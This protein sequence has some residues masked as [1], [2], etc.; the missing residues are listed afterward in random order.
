MD[1]KSFLFGEEFRNFMLNAI[2]GSKLVSGGKEILC[3]CKYCPDSSNPEH[4][5]MYIHIPD[6]KDDIA[7]FNCFKCHTSGIIDSRRLIEW[8]IYDFDVALN[9]DGIVKEASAYNKLR[10]YSRIIYRFNNGFYN[11]DLAQYKLNYIN[12]RLGLNLTFADCLRNKIIFNLKD[13]LDYNGIRKYTRHENIIQ[14]LND[15]FIGFLSVDNNFV[16]L[17]RLC[18]EGIV[19]K[20]IDK[21]YINYN[22]HDKKDN[23]D[24]HYIIPTILNLSSTQPINI[25]IAEGPFDILSIYY[26]LRYNEINNS[27]FAA[28]GGS[29]YLPL[30]MNIIN[31]YKIYYFNLHIYPDNDDPGGYNIM[32]NIIQVLDPFNCNIFIHRN[33]YPGEKDFGVPLPRINEQILSKR[34]YLKY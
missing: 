32:K 18:D 15:N 17:R 34:D 14:E 13:S 7:V 28:I 4:A 16:N 12:S 20:S 19:Y 29:G 21:R 8:G 25:H 1:N 23:T 2:P 6:S 26:N 30:I 3:R 22:I 9:L 24:K 10:G 5:H 33:I 27:L 11:K 31:T